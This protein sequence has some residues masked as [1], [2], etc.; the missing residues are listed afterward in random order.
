MVFPTETSLSLPFHRLLL[1]PF[2]KHIT[3]SPPLSPPFSVTSTVVAVIC[4]LHH[5]RRYLSTQPSPLFSS[6]SSTPCF[7]TIESQ[8]NLTTTGERDLAGENS[9]EEVQAPDLHFSRSAFWVIFF[10]IFVF[11]V[12]DLLC[13]VFASWRRSLVAGELQRGEKETNSGGTRDE[14]KEEVGGRGKPKK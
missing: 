8:P 10:S 5:H 2:S 9:G 7:T 11:Y 1:S 6:G 12:I 13:F 3:H 14:G 4:H